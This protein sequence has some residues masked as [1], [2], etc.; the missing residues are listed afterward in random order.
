MTMT[1]AAP[2][3]SA[4]LRVDDVG[5]RYGKKWVLRGCS[6]DLRPGA[7]TALIGPNGAGKSTLMSTAAGLLS[8][9]EGRIEV[10][11]SPVV[12]LPSHPDLAYLAQDKPLYRRYRVRDMLKIARHLNA[13]WDRAHADELIDAANLDRAQR[14]ATLSGGQRTRLAL[15][16]VLARRPE[17]LL[18]DEPLADLDPLARLEVQQAL[19]TEVA[20]TGMTVLMSSHILGEVVDLCEDVLVMGSGRITL[21][22]QIDEVLAAHRLLVGPG[23]S[24]DDLGF[25]PA[26]A[27][28]EAQHAA[29]QTTL[30]LDR[31]VG[32]LPDGWTAFA[33]TLDEVIVAYLRTAHTADR[34][35]GDSNGACQ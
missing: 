5:Q 9:T 11:G 24:A 34:A 29:R 7:V 32:P 17:V 8:P 6:F 23:T 26:G 28:I 4:P 20:D 25:V 14:V 16:L 30:L 19:M 15:A 10:K 2:V 21:A 3:E 13:R 27:I 18:L 12:A 1:A 35:A 22:G 31:P 33:P